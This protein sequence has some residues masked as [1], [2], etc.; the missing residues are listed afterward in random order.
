MAGPLDDKTLTPDMREAIERMVRT[1]SVALVRITSQWW[2]AEADCPV[3]MVPVGRS[4][5]LANSASRRVRDRLMYDKPV[6]WTGTVAALVRRRVLK[7]S[8]RMRA[9]RGFPVE[10]PPYE[11]AEFRHS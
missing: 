1:Q 11:R 9:R 2:A 8:G 6:F 7:F 4:I 3:G 10:Q 5:M